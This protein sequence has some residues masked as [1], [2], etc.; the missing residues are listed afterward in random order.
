MKVDLF[1]VSFLYFDSKNVLYK[2]I[3]SIMNKKDATELGY[4]KYCKL[5]TNFIKIW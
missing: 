5:A 1:V 3:L 2:K 4:Y